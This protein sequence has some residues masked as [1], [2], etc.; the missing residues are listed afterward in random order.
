MTPH[1]SNAHPATPAAP[2]APTPEVQATP[3]ASLPGLAALDGAN[4]ASG[5][6][7]RSPKAGRWSKRTRLLVSV[8]VAVLVLG[9]TAAAYIVIE[10]PFKKTHP[11]LVTA[12]VKRGVLELKIIE[13]GQLESA[14]NSDIV[15][16]VK[17]KTQGGGA[18][19]IRW[20]VDDGTRVKYDRPESEVKTAW[21]WDE[22]SGTYS[23][24]TINPTGHARCVKVR[25]PKTG[26]WDLPGIGAGTLGLLAS[27]LGPTNLLGAAALYPER[28]GRWLYADLLIQL[29]DSYL[30]DQKDAKKIELDGARDAEF[31]AE[32]ALES[33]LSQ[34]AAA[35]QKAKTDID[36]AEVALEGFLKGDYIAKI[37]DYDAKIKSAQSDRDQQID[38]VAW[39]NRMLKKGFQT[40]S[41]AQSEQLK[42]E[43]YE[44]TLGVAETNMKSYRDFERKKQ[45]ITLRGAIA[46]AKSAYAD[47]KVQAVTKEDQ[48]RSTL[49]TKKSVHAQERNR[50]RD[51]LEQIQKCKVHAPRSGIAVY[52]IPEQARWGA[53]SRQSIVAQGE[54]VSEGQKMMQIPD[55][56]NLLVN[57]KVHEALA[58]RVH[59]GQDA[60]IRVDSFNDR[61]LK[62]K[63][64]FVATVAAAESFL[65]ADVRV[66]TTKI[67]VEDPFEGLRPG[68]NAEVKI[69]IGDAVTDALMV[70]VEAVVGGVEMGEERTVYVLTEE[71]PQ[72][73]KVKI[74]KANAEYVQ[75][76][77]GLKE[78]EDVVLNP[79]AIVGDK[80]KTRKPGEGL[81]GT[82]EKGKKGGPGKGGKGQ[83]G[84]GGRPGAGVPSARPGGG[85]PRGG[86]QFDPKQM[87]E[88]R[89][90]LFN[91]LR[92]APKEKRK[93]I[94]EQKVPADFR[95]MAKEGARAAGI[96]IPD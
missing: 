67:A 22:K 35:I 42:L 77:D 23:E 61:P 63:V 72:E 31:Q 74:G 52:Y 55:L 54:P 18:T 45:E 10:K 28:I 79:K 73:R 49:I 58:P 30:L 44:L 95:E 88:R 78:G 19:N 76:T 82:E 96:D 29:D 13:R 51:I 4:G 64:K 83:G 65:A 6:P 32:K 75:I 92:K 91:E 59:A 90:A 46:T 17:A 81:S 20:L 16:Q 66:Y 62:G 85:A 41:Q 93:A 40:A 21:I 3:A 26:M 56:Q 68:S 27:P 71:G 37:K 36:V 57:T 80:V 53:G 84:R 50:Y 69:T 34:N 94:L 11:E 1:P 7:S 8:G 2:P 33:A 9:S 86:A 43:S 60:T 47:A 15:C 38:R 12:K 14:N 87:E 5:R 89:K 24:E 70:P 48:A 25:D 39:A